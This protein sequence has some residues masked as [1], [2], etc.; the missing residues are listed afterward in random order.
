MKNAWWTVS[1]ICFLLMASAS[2]RAEGGQTLNSTASDG[3]MSGDQLPTAKRC[4]AHPILEYLFESGAG[5]D[6]CKS[7]ATLSEKPSA[8]W[9]RR[10]T[11]DTISHGRAHT[12]E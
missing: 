12:D 9:F 10:T 1:V 2:G 11:S 6:L 8:R 3:A 7:A 5:Y 4:S